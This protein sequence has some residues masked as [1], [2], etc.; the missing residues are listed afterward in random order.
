MLLNK[1]KKYLDKLYRI[2]DHSA[3]IPYLEAQI[4]TCN[5]LVSKLLIDNIKLKGILDDIKLAEFKVHSQT[6]E[7]GIIQ[8]LIHHINPPKTFIEFGVEN[9]LESNTRFLLINDNWKGLVLDG[10]KSQINSIRRQSVYVTNH[11]FVCDAFITKENINQ[12]IESN[13]F[14]GEVGL[15][16]IDIDGNDYWVWESITCI[17]P[18]IVIC[19][20]NALFGDT[21]KISVPYSHDFVAA[22]AHYSHLYFGASLQALIYLAEKKGY[23]F[24]G[25]N[26]N[27]SNAFFVRKDKIGNLKITTSNESFVEPLFR[28]SRHEDGTLSYLSG[29]ERLQ[30][31]KGLPV[32]NVE[33]LDLEFL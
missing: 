27:G 31:I 9:Y 2:D 32:V 4:H 15:L 23:Y 7:D 3:K 11:L 18:Q 16:S 30:L 10:N 20:Y 21:R 14:N 26:S 28:S 1:I 24:V 6:G 13:K 8:Y 12:L 25:N 22:K 19:E 29:D 33:T 5:I 17:N